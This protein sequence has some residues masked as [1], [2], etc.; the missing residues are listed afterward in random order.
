MDL[1]VAYDVSTESPEGR[2]RLRK[3]AQACQN[4]GQRVQFS[5]FECRVTDA[6]W[7]RF[8]DSLRRIVNPEED[9]I[10][11]YRLTGNHDDSVWCL[12]IDRYRDFD[13]PL[14]V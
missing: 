5:V 14:I 2:K 12:G 8:Q 10:R 1:V 4:Y 11:V 3:V 6:E 7:A 13:G 9:S